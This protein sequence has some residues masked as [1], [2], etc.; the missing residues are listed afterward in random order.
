MCDKEGN[1]CVCEC[2]TVVGSAG[3]ARAVCC[4]CK[5]SVSVFS[6]TAYAVTSYW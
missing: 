3:S 4:N 5:G 1:V 2:P 6:Y